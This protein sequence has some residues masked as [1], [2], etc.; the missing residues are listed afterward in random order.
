MTQAY[1]KCTTH[2]VIAPD[3]EVLAYEDLA[4][5]DMVAIK[6]Q[7]VIL[8]MR[9]HTSA[10]LS[11]NTRKRKYPVDLFVQFGLSF[12]STDAEAVRVA[13]TKTLL[14]ELATMDIDLHVGVGY[15][16]DESTTGQ[17]GYGRYWPLGTPNREFEV[18]L[19]K[20]K[21]AQNCCSSKEWMNAFLQTMICDASSEIGWRE[22]SIQLL[23]M[24][25]DI[26]LTFVD[27]VDV[28]STA[29]DPE[30][31]HGSCQLK[32]TSSTGELTY[33]KDI[34]QNYPSIAAIS[35]LAE[36][37]DI[38]LVFVVSPERVMQYE[39][40]CHRVA[41]CVVT[42]LD[43]KLAD[44]LALIKNEYLKP[45]KFIKLSGS[46]HPQLRFTL[47]SSCGNQ[48]WQKTDKCRGV[49]PGSEVEW[50]IKVDLGAAEPYYPEFFISTSDFEQHMSAMSGRLEIIDGCERGQDSLATSERN[51]LEAIIN[52]QESKNNSQPSITRFPPASPWPLWAQ[53][54]LALGAPGV[55]GIVVY[56]CCIKAQ[57]RRKNSRRRQSAHIDGIP[58][59]ETTTSFLVLPGA[60]ESRHTDAAI[61]S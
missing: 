28:Q 17:Y 35:K 55:V 36:D 7:R 37:K 8:R 16:G 23:V 32:S 6:P 49:Q 14:T 45:A 40:L 25:T 57:Q 27:G 61:S 46:S 15:F 50:K 33:D 21:T 60:S 1:R 38:H 53:L 22:D 29:S 44:V 43:N 30:D 12:N 4:L 18:R 47:F 51:N 42:S 10:T 20:A 11:V 41:R 48:D 54:T 52:P 58:S 9:P 2:D 19:K 3:N 56:G 5:S 59:T 26:P 31:G 39:R 24:V 34:V 13:L